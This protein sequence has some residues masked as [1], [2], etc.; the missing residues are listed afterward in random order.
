MKGGWSMHQKSKWISLGVIM[1]FSVFFSSG[2]SQ[3]D[4]EIK[5]LIAKNVEAVGGE[6][7]LAEIKNYSFKLG[8]QTVYLS[9]TG[10]MK[11]TSGKDPVVTEAILASAKGA[12]RNCFNIISDYEGFDKATYQALAKIRS[13][14]FT[15]SSYKDQLEYHGLK[16]FGPKNLHMLTAKEGELDVEFYIDSEDLLTKR[17]VFSGFSDETGKYEVNHDFVSFQEVEGIKIPESWFASQ[18][19]TRGN[20]NQVT[21]VKINVDLSD[22]F[23]RSSDVNVGEVEMSEGRLKG[24]VVDFGRMR[25]NRFQISTNWTN[26]CI[27]N[28]GFQAGD[29]LTLDV[30]GIH[31][32]LD[33]YDQQPPRSAYSSGALLIP[34]RQ[35]ENFIVYILTSEYGDFS[36]KLE[37]LMPI[38]VAKK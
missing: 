10:L 9:S 21:D 15:L 11:L 1:V 26:D 24:N 28:A 35:S 19:G 38:Q 14:F 18:V 34:N 8:E 30:A 16:K 32:E 29:K 22:D 36:E 31:I 25:G 2:C 4:P 6:E 3:E 20:L 5:N 12:T 23:F 13:A 37:P 27:Q 33:F 7:K 17:I